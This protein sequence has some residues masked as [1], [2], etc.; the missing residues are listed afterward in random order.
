M[1]TNMSIAIQVLYAFVALNL[2]FIVMIYAIKFKNVKKQ[3]KINSF[4]VNFKDYLTYIQA[5]L[6]RDERLRVP[7]IPMNRVEKETLQ[8]WLNDMIDSF[9]GEQR[10]KLIRLCE[11]LG[12]IEYHSKRLNGHSYQAKVDAAY[13]LGCMRVKEA[14]PALMEFL[15]GHQ[16]DSSLFVI[17][18]AVARCARHSQDIK[19]MVSIL[20]KHEKGFYDLI[21]DMIQE[22]NVD[23]T[24][25]FAEFVKQKNPA[26]MKIGLTGLK[27]Y[28]D[29]SV[30]SAVY[31]LIDFEDEDIQWKA[32]KIYLKS[33]TFMPRN[34]VGKLI[35][36]KRADIR[37]L[38][39]QALSELRNQAYAPDL[40]ESL[41]DQDKRVIY[42]AA[43]GL[44]QMGEGGMTALCQGALEMRG[45]GHGLGEYLQ[46]M[47]EEEIQRLSLQ[48]H[49]LEQLT[50]YNTLMYAYEKT[51]GKNKRIYR[52]V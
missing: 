22:A 23:Q 39:V 20:L 8:E 14:V 44:L 40:K 13:H 2:V 35:R 24:A 47:V 18:R 25:L 50:R 10:Q 52:I 28:N 48:L 36:H 38:A 51:F 6:E 12:F 34:I 16:Y 9:T 27:E 15:R 1:Y 37:L 33:S 49:D 41:K 42:A 4:H 29:P 43:S 30:A 11:D 21:V 46:A 32:V 7:P 17:A 26:L 45:E 31:Q 3:K 19:E 5:H